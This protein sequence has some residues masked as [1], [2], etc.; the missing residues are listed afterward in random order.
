MQFNTEDTYSDQTILD[1]D[2][3]IDDYLVQFDQHLQM[4]YL[5]EMCFN[6]ARTVYIIVWEQGCVSSGG[7]HT[8][9]MQGTFVKTNNIWKHKGISACKYAPVAMMDVELLVESQ[10]KKYANK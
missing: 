9:H 7:I 10:K 8:D 4:E 2:K 1:L 5:A 6:D 3:I